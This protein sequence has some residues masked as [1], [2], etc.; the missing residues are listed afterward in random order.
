MGQGLNYGDRLGGDEYGKGENYKVG[1][2][3]LS[4][5]LYRR[6]GKRNSEGK[7]HLNQ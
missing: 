7:V 5:R 1:K 2:E 3:G 6:K 4:N